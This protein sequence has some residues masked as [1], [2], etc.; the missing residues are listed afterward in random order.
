MC[1]KTAEVP[2]DKIQFKASSHGG[3]AV[4]PFQGCLKKIFSILGTRFNPILLSKTR[5]MTIL[6]VSMSS[7]KFSPHPSPGSCSGNKATSSSL[8]TRR[9]G[10]YTLSP[11][12]L[13]PGENLGFFLFFGLNG[14]QCLYEFYV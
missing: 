7:F 2:G 10:E 6:A 5:F 11:G 13:S 1:S 14:R 3:F 4:S 9:L 8:A 12:S